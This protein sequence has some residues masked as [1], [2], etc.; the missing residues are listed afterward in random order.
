MKKRIVV[1]FS[2]TVL[3]VYVFS[4]SVAEAQLA[5]VET[6][7]V[8]NKG[9]NIHYVK[10]GE[11][12]L[13]LFLHGFPD[14]WYT[15]KPI[16]NQLSKDYTTV[17]IDLRGY[18]KSDSPKGLEHYKMT[19]LMSDVVAVIDHFSDDGAIIVANDW[20]GAIAW[21][22]TAYFPEKVKAMA[23]LNIP[24]PS[25]LFSYLRENPSTSEYTDK[26]RTDGAATNTSAE[27]LARLVA[28][29]TEMEAY[30]QAFR[31]S[32]FQAMFNYYKANY[33]K[34]VKGGSVINQKRMPEINQPLMIIHG[35]KDTAFPP[36]MLANF[37][38]W[39]TGEISVQLF[40]DSGHF[41]QKEKPERISK[42]LHAWLKDLGF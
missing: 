20:G 5:G 2:V 19:A 15:W 13:I 24:H 40:P 25:S 37:W 30:T 39:T 36:G 21:Q 6:G 38:E 32:D 10:Q 18:N 12:Q 17:A 31:R 41:I 23:A 27:E 11:G 4:F 34:P 9:V 35:L 42:A 28:D 14:F 29:E 16:M 3:A 26:Y 22:V 8:N 7:Y 1:I 33:P